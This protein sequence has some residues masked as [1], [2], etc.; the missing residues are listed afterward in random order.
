VSEGCRD[1]RGEVGVPRMCSAKLERCGL[2]LEPILSA[3]GIVRPMED[4]EL[5]R[6]SFLS[7]IAESAWSAIA[8]ARRYRGRGALGELDAAKGF[9]FVVRC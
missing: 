2:G 6:E 4:A 9:G 1:A 5:L 8:T 7:S 3:G